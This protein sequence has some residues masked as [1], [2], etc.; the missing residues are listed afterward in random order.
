MD[1]QLLHQTTGLSGSKGVIQG[2]RG[3]GGQVIHHQHDFL[4][5][6]VVD[7]DQFL[8]KMS[9]ILAGFLLRHLHHAFSRQWF[10]GQLSLIGGVLRDSGRNDLKVILNH[11]GR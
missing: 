7:I 11:C 5:L 2:R 3:M 9:P 6:G 4:R 1:L 10:A 8:D